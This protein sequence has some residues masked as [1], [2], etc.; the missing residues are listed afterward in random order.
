METEIK[1]SFVLDDVLITSFCLTNGVSLLNIVEDRSGHFQFILA[2]S[3]RCEQLKIK[4]LNNAP[5]PARELFS[6]REMLI[7]EI[8]NRTRDRGTST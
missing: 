6:Q 8:K 1:D 7:S 2:D 4:Y 5:A 3:K